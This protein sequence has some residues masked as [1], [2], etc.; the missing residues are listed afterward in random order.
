MPRR[1]E[2]PDLPEFYDRV[3]RTLEQAFGPGARLYAP[4]NETSAHDHKSAIRAFV[5]LIVLCLAVA[6]SRML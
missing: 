3:P 2:T 6:C 1:I 4:E 5:I